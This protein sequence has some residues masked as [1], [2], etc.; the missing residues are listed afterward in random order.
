MYLWVRSATGGV[1]DRLSTTS[2]TIIAIKI[3]MT[4]TLSVTIIQLLLNASFLSLV[5]LVLLPLSSPP[6]RLSN[7]YHHRPLNLPSIFSSRRDK[8]QWDTRYFLSREP[9]ILSEMSRDIL[10]V[11][12]IGFR[13]FRSYLHVNAY[14]LKYTYICV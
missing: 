2:M 13:V 10:A 4:I 5:L 7:D 12:H 8:E 14:V 3:P 6:Y 11:T 9:V 1:R